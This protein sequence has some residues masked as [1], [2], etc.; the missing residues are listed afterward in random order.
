MINPLQAATG[1]GARTAAMIPDSGS[2]VEN[3]TYSLPGDGK[4][5]AGSIIRIYKA[6]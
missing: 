4:Y 2:A 1:P 6:I 5:G 3:G